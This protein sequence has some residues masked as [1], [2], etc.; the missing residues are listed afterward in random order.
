MGEDNKRITQFH[1]IIGSPGTFESG[2][3]IT[4]FESRLTIFFITN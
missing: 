4:I 3:D 2:N 1:N